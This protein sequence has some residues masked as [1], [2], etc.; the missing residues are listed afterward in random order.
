MLLLASL[1]ASLCVADS[2]P[3]STQVHIALIP[4]DKSAISFVTKAPFDNPP[5]VYL[6][7]VD[8]K[9]QNI[10]VNS[11]QIPCTTISEGNISRYYHHA[12]TPPLIAHQQYWYQPGPNASIFSFT[13]RTLTNDGAQNPP[14]NILLYGDLGVSH[15]SDTMALIKQLANIS[16]GGT[17]PTDIDFILHFGDIAYADDRDVIYPPSNPEYAQIYDEWGDA[18]QPIF[19]TVPYMTGPGNHEQTCHS[20]SDW[21]C[22]TALENFTVYRA[23]FRMPSAAHGEV[24]GGAS[25]MWWSMDYKNVHILTISTE[26]DYPG[27]PDQGGIPVI[28]FVDADSLE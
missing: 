14:I 12:V 25:N 1:L 18:M 19:S 13:A 16:S 4:P 22:H 9:L 7:A 20:W 21:H 6:S 26:T 11:T 23:Y 28:R 3:L 17:A 15:S 8:P 2:I 27:S 24:G 5:I 10:T